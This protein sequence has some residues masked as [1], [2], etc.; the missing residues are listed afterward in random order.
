MQ[1]R[2][3][4]LV[5]SEHLGWSDVLDTLRSF[6][7]VRLVGEAASF[8]EGLK[9]GV[10]YQPDV[11]ILPERSEDGTAKSWLAAY[12]A[13]LPSAA[14]RPTLITIADL[15]EEASREELCAI[16]VRLL[17]KDL[18]AATLQHLLAASIFSDTVII[19][20]DI[21]TTASLTRGKYSNLKKLPFPLNDRERAVLLLLADGLTH[22]EIARNQGLSQRTVER[23]I[24]GLEAKFDAHD[25]FALGWRAGQLGLDKMA[26]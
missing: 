24:S 21:A 23:I 7:G 9:L 1:R 16:T 3:V 4:L 25:S 12:R 6:D 20:R 26:V 5:R 8:D 15:A 13:E 14:I 11:V 22:K 17:W 10:A 2:T 19:S 18:S